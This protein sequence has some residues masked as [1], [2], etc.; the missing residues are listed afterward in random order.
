MKTRAILALFLVACL[1]VCGDAHT[2]ICPDNPVELF[3]RVAN[4]AVSICPVDLC[5]DCGHTRAC[6]STHQTLFAAASF[7]LT[8]SQENDCLSAQV[9]R[10]DYPFFY[11]G[12]VAD[13]LPGL[14]APP[15][16]SL[17][18]TPLQLKQLL[19]I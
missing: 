17:S 5:P 12:A 10:R 9:L 1:W 7:S 2:C 15:D 8:D 11:G 18:F 19:L 4:C 3:N 13:R 14:R 16:Y 6:C